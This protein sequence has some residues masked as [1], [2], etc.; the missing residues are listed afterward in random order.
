[1]SG[2]FN[3]AALGIF[4]VVAIVFAIAATVLAFIFI[5]PEKKREKLG[6]FGKFVHDTVNFKY[7]IVEKILQALYIFA[8]AYTILCGFFMLFMTSTTWTGTRWLGGWGILLMLLGP[9][10]IRLLYELLM[11][12]VLLVKNVI[13]INCKLRA[14]DGAKANDVFAAPDMSGLR[15][16]LQKKFAKEEPEKPTFC[17]KCG[18]KLD[19]GGACPNCTAQSND[20]K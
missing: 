13:V 9:I 10:V 14:Q 1:M 16:K 4:S 7:L 12:A 18:T 6:T 15:E 2:M 17:A 5:V 19:E 20:Q 8:T 11:R 3:F